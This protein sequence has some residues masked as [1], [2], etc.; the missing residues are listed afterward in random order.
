MQAALVPTR[1]DITSTVSQVPP[2]RQRRRRS[3]APASA[4]K[5]VHRRAGSHE[6]LCVVVWCVVVFWYF[7][8]ADV[9]A[10]DKAAERAQSDLR[11]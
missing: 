7:T 9:V 6:N 1:S 3:G 10:I 4:A 11:P 2:S 5:G 8:V